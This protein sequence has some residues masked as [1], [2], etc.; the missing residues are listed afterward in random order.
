M[1]RLAGLAFACVAAIAIASESNAAETLNAAGRTLPADAAARF[2]VDGVNALLTHPLVER[3]AAW[4]TETKFLEG[5]WERPDVQAFYD[6]LSLLESRVGLSRHELLTKLT[7]RGIAAALIPGPPPRVVIVAD[8]ADESL[9]GRV[10]QAIEEFA[11]AGGGAGIEKAVYQGFEYRRLGGLHVAIKDGRMLLSGDR[12]SLKEIVDRLPQD[13]SPQAPEFGPEGFRIRLTANVSALRAAP[14]MQKGLEFPATDVGAVAILGGWIDLLRSFDRATI[15]LS[16]TKSDIQIR[17]TM[18]EPHG[19]N[20]SPGLEGF[21]A[22]QGQTPLRLLNPPGTVYSTSW[23]RNYGAMWDSHEKLIAG[24]LGKNLAM[25]DADAGVQMQVVGAEF[26]PSQ[27]VTR[28]GPHFR[29]VLLEGSAPYPEV[30]PPNLLP[31]AV[32]V[33]EL[34][35][36]ALVRKWSG[37]VLRIL[38]LILNGDQGIISTTEKHAGA[39]L[40]T[41]SQP[42]TPQAIRKG[43]LDRFNFRTTYTFA[44]GSFVIGSTPAAVK[45]V[46]DDLA[47]NTDDA[48]IADGIIT[49]ELQLLNADRTS[50]V[51]DAIQESLLRSF[52]LQAGLTT[53]DARSERDRLRH[54]LAGLGVLKADAGMSDRGFEYRIEWTLPAG[55]RELAADKKSG[56]Q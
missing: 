47:T 41:L 4:A 45:A 11:V 51:L 20:V 6:T 8:A 29:V 22:Q 27:L 24:E 7:G 28:L 44:H 38:N 10:L 33:V 42:V 9:P 46:L 53:E 14:D 54:L 2:E 56:G 48:R 49:T 30:S 3:V 55:D 39:D 21:W 37:P 15:E 34:K 19:P 32:A 25:V 43:S 1:K 17:A 26:T 18:S 23:C 12:D 5:Y 52:V 50:S 40:S 35:D 36:E 16:G 31:A 13:A